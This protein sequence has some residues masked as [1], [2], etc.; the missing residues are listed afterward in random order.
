MKKRQVKILGL[1]Y[2]QSQIGSY[3]L[4][5]SEMKGKVKLPVI[6]K[7][8]DAQRIALDLEGIKSTKPLIHDLFISMTD[9]FGIDVQEVFIYSL[10]EGIFYTKIICTN[11]LD[12]IEIESSIGDGVILASLYDCPIFVSSDVMNS[13]GVLIN[14]DGTSL[15]NDI[16]DDNDD[17]VETEPERVTTIENLEK[18]LDH[19][20]ANEE[21][22]I[23]AQVRDRIEKMKSST[24]ENQSK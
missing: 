22:E 1:S 4:V 3:V 6:I 5:L 14:D 9:S 10:A 7:P 18:M 13:A 2:S 20:V 24:D 19:A 12:D 17:E 21:Y 8:Q 15:S 23:A 11:G 16:T